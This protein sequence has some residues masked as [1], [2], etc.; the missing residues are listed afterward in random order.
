MDGPD[1]RLADY[2]DVIAGTSSSTGGLVTTMITAPNKDKQPMHAAKDIIT[3]FYLEESLKIL[4][5]KLYIVSSLF[6]NYYWSVLFSITMY[7]I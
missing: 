2:F 4:P 5:Q 3:S 6:Y 7:S 1:A